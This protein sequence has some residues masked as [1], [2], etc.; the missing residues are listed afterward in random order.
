[1]AWSGN[2]GLWIVNWNM[3]K[4]ILRK[5]ASRNLKKVI[6]WRKIEW[7][8]NFIII[9]NGRLLKQIGT[10]EVVISRSIKIRTS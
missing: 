10:K 5:K 6:P 4:F 8:I 3:Y 9:T 1:M 7:I 2:L